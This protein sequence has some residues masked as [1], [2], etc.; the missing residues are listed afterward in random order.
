MRSSFLPILGAV[1]FLSASADAD[2]PSF[3]SKLHN[4]S[5]IAS[6]V[7]DNGDVNR[8]GVAPGRPSQRTTRHPDSTGCCA[9]ALCHRPECPTIRSETG[10][11][12]ITFR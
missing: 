11:Y 3:L 9:A 7:P 1:L 8:Y 12:R 10:Q 2:D 6:T 4:V 5:M